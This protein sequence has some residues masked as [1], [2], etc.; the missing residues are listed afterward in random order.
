MLKF[1][2]Y[3]YFRIKHGADGCWGTGLPVFLGDRKKEGRIVISM[4]T[5]KNALWPQI[6]S[7][8]F[9]PFIYSSKFREYDQAWY[10]TATLEVKVGGSRFNASPGKTRRPY[11]KNKLRQKECSG[12]AC[13]SSGRVLA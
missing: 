11:L 3:V 5:K 12:V 4:T 8:T 9:N 6:L 2:W 13:G 10:L 1:R 7:G